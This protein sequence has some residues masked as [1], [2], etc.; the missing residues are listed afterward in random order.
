[1]TSSDT[2]KRP[3]FYTA[4]PSRGGKALRLALGLRDLRRVPARNGRAN[5]IFCWGYVQGMGLTRS[6]VYNPPNKVAVAANKLKFFQAMAAA[7]EEDRPRIPEFTTSAAEAIKWAEDGAIVIGRQTLSGHSGEGIVFFDDD[8]YEAFVQ[9]PMF[10]K[11]VKNLAEYRIHFA[12]GER[13]DTQRK[14]LRTDAPPQDGPRRVKNLANG[15]VYSRNNVG[16]VPEDV[17]VQAA[18]AFK[19]SGLDYGAVDVIYN[20]YYNQAY[21]L[22]INTAPGLEGTTLENYAE[23]FRRRL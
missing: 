19:A 22:E 6:T 11:Y 18:K 16:E 20:A 9:C 17:Y 23:A 4:R 5:P 21:V 13:I 3:Y 10:V 2:E 15:F 8:D 12:F 7:P 14:A 1:M